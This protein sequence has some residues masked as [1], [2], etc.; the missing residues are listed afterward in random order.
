MRK[1]TLL[2]ITIFITYAILLV[3]CSSVPKTEESKKSIID[4]TKKEF[5]SI[6]KTDL[7]TSPPHQT[8]NKPVAKPPA[9]IKEVIKEKIKELVKESA[10]SSIQNTE[11]TDRSQ[12]SAKNQERLQEINQNLSFFCMKHRKDKTFKDEDHCLAF[13]KKVL[14]KCERKHKLINTI[15][16]NCIKE[17]LKKR[18]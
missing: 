8:I 13:T 15:M 17:H 14:K 5:E 4:N 6:E 2:Q 12:L 3:S 10:G 18:Q 9:Q 16:V 1:M 11:S 7:R